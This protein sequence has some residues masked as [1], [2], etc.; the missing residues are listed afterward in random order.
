MHY[1]L[2]NEE[3]KY[4]ARREAIRKT[5]FFSLIMVIVTSI[6]II[7]N[8]NLLTWQIKFILIVLMLIVIVCL[9]ILVFL[10]MYWYYIEKFR[11]N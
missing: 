6:L 10:L 3:V 7:T 9:S 5:L 2:S 11:E 1:G 4:F 8:P